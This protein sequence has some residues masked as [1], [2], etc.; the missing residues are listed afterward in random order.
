[1]AAVICTFTP[2]AVC[3]VPATENLCHMPA[4]SIGL[5]LRQSKKLTVVGYNRFL[6]SGNTTQHTIVRL[7]HGIPHGITMVRRLHVVITHGLPSIVNHGGPWSI[8]RQSGNRLTSLSY[9][10]TPLD[11][12]LPRHTVVQPGGNTTWSHHGVM[13]SAV[14]AYPGKCGNFWRYTMVH[15]WCTM[16]SM[17]KHGIP[18]FW[19]TV[20]YHSIPR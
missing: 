18:C 11:S 6:C 4:E 16:V 14:S 7:H 9:R 15:R 1:V 17:V 19:F 10:G 3:R 5:Q 12:S 8:V 20:V 13:Y 2:I